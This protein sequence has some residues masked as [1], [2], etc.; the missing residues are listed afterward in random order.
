MTEDEH[1]LRLLSIFYYIVGGLTA[2]CSC[3]PI[4]HLL[5]GIAIVTGNLPTEPK[6]PPMPEMVGWLF[7]VFASIFILFGWAYAIGMVMAGLRLQRRRSYTYCIVIAALSCINMP[8]GT[9]L[10]VFTLIVLQRPS[11][12][13]L[14]G[15]A[16]MSPSISEFD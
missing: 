7:I 10:G 5:L 15:K 14:F 13:A 16:R 8:F 9:C 11:V 2:F 6:G 3:F 4:I 1:H 12:K